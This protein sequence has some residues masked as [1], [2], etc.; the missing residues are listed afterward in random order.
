[1]KNL[2]A[3]LALGLLLNGC[4]GYQL[5]S[6]LPRGLRTIYVPTFENVSGEPDVDQAATRAVIAEFQQDGTVEVAT[7]QDADL[8]MDATVTRYQ[9]ES[10]RYRSDRA[11][12]ADEFRIRLY[13]DVVVRYA[14]DGTVFMK[15][16]G[17]Q[18]EATFLL[19]S[20]MRTAKLAALPEAAEDLAHDIVEAVVE[21]W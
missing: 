3:A 12:T 7:A 14:R 21:H 13:A 9:V 15:R 16:S 18:G 4:A 20:D 2:L 11:T 17:V 10:L 5:G 6:T 19:E 1:M 8:R